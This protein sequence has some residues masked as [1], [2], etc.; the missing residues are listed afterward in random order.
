MS[1]CLLRVALLIPEPHQA[2]TLPMP[3]QSCHF[4]SQRLRNTASGIRHTGSSS[5][6]MSSLCSLCVCVHVCS[7]FYLFIC[8]T[9][10]FCISFAIYQH[11]STTGVHEF[12]ILNPPPTYL[13]I[14]SPW[15]IPVDQ[16]QAACILHQTQ[17]GN[18]FLHDSIHVSM[19]FSQI[20]PPSP[21]ESKSP[22]YTSVSLLLSC[23]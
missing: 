17:T 5:L 3:G 10:Q 6:Q 2:F 20:I 15:V 22:L 13:P 7:H 8:F 11:E 9:L 16:P 14:P 4:L 1:K 12:P 21:S 23:I 18:S 19:P